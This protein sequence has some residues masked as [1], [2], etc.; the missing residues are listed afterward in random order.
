M[1]SKE[2]LNLICTNPKHMDNSIQGICMK[3]D[4]NK[5]RLT[6][7]DCL[8]EDHVEHM[9]EGKSFLGLQ[10]EVDKMKTSTVT[11]TK[12]EVENYFDRLTTKFLDEIQKAK[13]NIL[14]Y[15]E[16][17]KTND[18]LLRKKREKLTEENINSKIINELNSNVSKTN[19]EKLNSKIGDLV[20]N[21]NF[22]EEENKQKSLPAL[23]KIRIPNEDFMS[24]NITEIANAI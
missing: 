10:A 20:K 11:S 13:Q 8:F 7:F 2:K 3:K 18:D 1:N 9:K 4:C 19:I 22:K 15:I 14:N 5:T 21:Y 24:K 17:N 6:C 12:E 16:D 23:A